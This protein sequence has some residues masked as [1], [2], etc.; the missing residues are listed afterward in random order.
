MPPP[1]YGAESFAAQ[2]Q[3]LLP[4][5]RIWHRGLELVQDAD[6]LALMPLW[7]RLHVRLNRLIAELFPCTPPYELL[8]EWE[9][10]LGLP[11]PCIGPLPTL[12]QRQSAVCV[13]F[14]ARGGQSIDYYI[15]L[16]ASVG[17]TARVVQFA[18]FRA[19]I[20]RCGDHLNGEAWAH[21]WA[22]IIPPPPTIVWFRAGLSTAGE[23]L[24]TWGDKIFE[25]MIRAAA[26]AHTVIIFRYALKSSIWD[27]RPDG[28]AAS[29]WDDGDSIWDQQGVIIG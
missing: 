19:S 16:A 10:S 21:A 9:E 4:R 24:R 18:P 15:R 14:T 2:F 7:A 13:K 5:G 28:T 12:Q 11:D 20:N 17:V 8:P 1:V 26:P 27:I 25:C 3:R 29:I 6:I 23:P 22:I